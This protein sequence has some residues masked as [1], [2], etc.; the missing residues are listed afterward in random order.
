MA[1][2]E[3]E[4]TVSKRSISCANKKVSAGTISGEAKGGTAFQLSN[5]AEASTKKIWALQNMQEQA[6]A[7][8]RP[9]RGDKTQFPPPSAQGQPELALQVF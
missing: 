4:G 8:K 1:N 2:V 5:E 9:S 3:V 7:P 6:T